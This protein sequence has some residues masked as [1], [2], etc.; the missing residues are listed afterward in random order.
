MVLLMSA[1]LDGHKTAK[2]KPNTNPTKTHRTNRFGSVPYLIHSNEKPKPLLPPLPLFCRVV[3]IT[4]T[5][6][7]PVLSIKLTGDFN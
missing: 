3:K 6:K 4:Q 1:L 7:I 2:E 5:G